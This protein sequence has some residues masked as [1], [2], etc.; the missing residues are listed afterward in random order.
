MGGTIALKSRHDGFEFAAYHA[1]PTDARRGGLVL[2]QEIFGVT[3]HIRELCDGFAQ[4]GY[5]VIAPAFYDRLEPGFAADYSPESIQKGVEYSQATPWDQVA[6]DAQAAIDA[7]SSPVFVTGYCWGGAAAWLVACRCDGVA[8]AAGY[9]GRRIS[10]LVDET[11]RC[12]TILHFG[13]TDASIP[14][15]KVDEIRDRH[16][17][18]AIYLY[19]AGHGFNSDRRRDYHAD[20]ARLARLRTLQLFARNAGIRSEM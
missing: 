13:K 17:D 14:L 9:Y 3:D 10:E 19:D 11:P 4:D 16:P 8:A 12:P 20:S 5:E 2:I 15:E 6:G 7:L 1:K 18:V